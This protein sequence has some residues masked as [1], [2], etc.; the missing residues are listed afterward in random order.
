MWRFP[1]LSRSLN[2]L[3]KNELVITER[4]KD[5]FSL[6]YSWFVCLFVFRCA[7]LN[8]IFHFIC[9]LVS[10]MAISKTLVP[11]ETFFG[12]HY[13]NSIGLCVFWKCKNVESVL[14]GRVSVRRL[15]VQFKKH[16]CYGKSPKN[17]KTWKV[18]IH[19][20]SSVH[21]AYMVGYTQN[22][23][24]FFFLYWNIFKEN[25]H[26]IKQINRKNTKRQQAGV[27]N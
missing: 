15:N 4:K 19:Q 11:V 23:G 20:I 26:N 7:C 27:Y 16:N 5:Q 6:W 8:R 21:L 9:V 18:R 12:S 10:T 14:L 13:K 2:I 22:H 17:M 3:I 24:D 1:S 25:N